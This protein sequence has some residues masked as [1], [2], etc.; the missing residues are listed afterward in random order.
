[1]LKYFQWTKN[2][3][4]RSFLRCVNKICSRLIQRNQI[5]SDGSIWNFETFSNQMGFLLKNLTSFRNG[6]WFIWLREFITID[7]PFLDMKFLLG[8]CKQ[9]GY[10]I[11]LK[12]TNS[13]IFWRAAV[14]FVR[15]FQLNLMSG[16]LLW[17]L[18]QGQF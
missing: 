7:F 6:H 13:F 9:S 16:I 8:W 5:F 4:R 3:K 18:K 17:L 11:G 15:H 10:A 2:G 12:R 1:M 14:Q